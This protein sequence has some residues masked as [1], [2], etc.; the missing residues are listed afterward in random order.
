MLN[1]NVKVQDYTA[2]SGIAP[3]ILS[4]GTRLTK[5]LTSRPGRFTPGKESAIPIKLEAGWSPE[6]VCTFDEDNIFFSCLDSNTG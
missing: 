1:E 2:T 5:R 3:L 4:L 6:S